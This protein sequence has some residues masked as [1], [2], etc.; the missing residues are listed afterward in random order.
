VSWYGRQLDRYPLT[1]KCLSSGIV[2]SMGDLICQSM[3]VTSES[4]SSLSSPPSDLSD[5]SSVSHG[6]TDGDGAEHQHQRD[7]LRLHRQQD[8][9][10]DWDWKRTGRF[11]IMGCCWVAPCTH[12]WYTALN[13]K[14]IPG[15]PTIRR[16]TTRVV[17]D[18]TLF[19]PIFCPSF[20]GLLWLLEGRGYRQNQSSSSSSTSSPSFEE[21]G[22]DLLDV[23][24]DII[25]ANWFVWIPA[26]AINFSVVPLQYQVLYGNVVAL[27]WNVFLSHKSQWKRQE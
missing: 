24:P 17:L 18:Q 10:W 14:L 3:T 22:K 12:Y 11:F 26:N 6:G 2:A 21:L 1:T 9:S 15:P 20:M 5:D 4:S 25:R 19:A 27:C 16:V 23:T 8:L 7:Q 13:T